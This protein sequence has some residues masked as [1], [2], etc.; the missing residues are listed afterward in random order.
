MF[1]DIFEYYV[2]SSVYLK[3]VFCFAS[4][5][6]NWSV[7]YNL[8]L[9]DLTKTFARLDVFMCGVILFVVWFDFILI[10]NYKYFI[11]F[12]HNLIF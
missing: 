9:F 3:D 5:F 7:A 8:N 2:K 6:A 12:N 11:I 1:H 4:L 10:I